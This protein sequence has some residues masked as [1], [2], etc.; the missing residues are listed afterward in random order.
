M[1]CLNLFVKGIRKL[2]WDIE[3][4]DIIVYENLYKSFSDFSY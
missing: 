4:F 2:N 3:V 1:R